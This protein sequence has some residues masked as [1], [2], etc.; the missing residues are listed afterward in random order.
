MKAPEGSQ[1][2]DVLQNELTLQLAGR[3]AERYDL[4]LT[5]TK[6]NETYCIRFSVGSQRTEDRHID[7]A[8]QVIS[9]EAREV[10]ADHNEEIQNAPKRAKSQPEVQ[11]FHS[12]QNLLNPD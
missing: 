1:Q 4:A 7:T 3:L 10:L 2:P 9:E 5:K 12:D 6:L 11:T 8:F